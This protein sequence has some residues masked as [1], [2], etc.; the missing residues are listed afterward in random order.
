[1]L[2]LAVPPYAE[3]DRLSL[4]ALLLL[5]GSLFVLIAALGSLLALALHR[6]SACSAA[7]QRQKLRWGATPPV[8]AA[9]RSGLVV[10]TLT[11][12]AIV[13][14]ARHHLCLGHNPAGEPN[15]SV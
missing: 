10:A 7:G 5:F 8:E 11:A 15:R 4:G 14:R 12:L 13:P 9:L 2:I 1:M 6:R 3:A